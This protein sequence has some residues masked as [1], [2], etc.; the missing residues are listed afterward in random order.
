MG[1]FSLIMSVVLLLQRYAHH[2]HHHIVGKG[3]ECKRSEFLLRVEWHVNQ[4]RRSARNEEHLLFA[5]GL[6]AQR[7]VGLQMQILEERA[8]HLAR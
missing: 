5:A 1:G 4:L 8:A 2:T 3:A 7:L 6:V